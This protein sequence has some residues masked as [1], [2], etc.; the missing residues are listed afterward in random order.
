MK[1]HTR[2]ILFLHRDLHISKVKLLGSKMATTIKGDGGGGGG[3]EHSFYSIS[4]FYTY[5]CIQTFSLF[6]Y[7]AHYSQKSYQDLGCIKP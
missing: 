1:I 6:L 7:G 2:L 4:L 3:G 5:F